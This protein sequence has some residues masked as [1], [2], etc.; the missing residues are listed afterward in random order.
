MV[1]HP[2]GVVLVGEG[3]GDATRRVG[4]PVVDDDDLVGVGDLAAYPQAPSP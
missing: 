4:A 1:D 3:V 2:D